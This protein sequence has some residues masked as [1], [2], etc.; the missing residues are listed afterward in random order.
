MATLV[1][2][3][4]GQPDLESLRRLVRLVDHL[5]F[6]DGATVSSNVSWIGISVGEAE[7]KWPDQVS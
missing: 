1:I 5:D 3:M 2:G 7:I 6:P 4:D